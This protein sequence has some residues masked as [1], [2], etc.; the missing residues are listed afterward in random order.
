MPTRKN[1]EDGLQW[2][3]R[4]I[5]PGDSLLFYFSGHGMRQR[6]L[7]GDEIDGFDETIC[8]VDFETNGMILDNYINHTLVRPLIQ[9]VTLHAIFD[10]CHSGTVLDLPFVYNITTYVRPCLLYRIDMD[11]LSQHL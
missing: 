4:G 11:S 10:S 7:H 6:S 1:I 5:K 9:G 2:L 3:M 8:P